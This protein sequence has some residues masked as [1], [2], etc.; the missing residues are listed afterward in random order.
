MIL[1]ENLI[2]YFSFK[3]RAFEIVF[4]M[5]FNGRRKDVVHNH[6][7]NVFRITLIAIETK[8]LRQ[9]CSWILVEVLITEEFDYFMILLM[10]T[11]TNNYHVIAKE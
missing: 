4:F 7:P 6:H 10:H 1:V 9:E 8:K 5:E 11:T 3:S 2:Q